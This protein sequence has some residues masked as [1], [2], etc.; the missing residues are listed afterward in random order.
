MSCN[1]LVSQIRCEETHVNYHVMR[2]KVQITSCTEHTGVQTTIF[3][4]GTF[5]ITIPTSQ[6]REGATN[7]S[8]AMLH[9]ERSKEKNPQFLTASHRRPGTKANTAK[10]VYAILTN[11][12]LTIT[13]VSSCSVFEESGNYNDIFAPNLCFI[14]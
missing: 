2:P 11:K 5:K 8:P 9:R 14:H 10:S 13:F 6:L 12:I 1:L 3:N 7:I 4:I